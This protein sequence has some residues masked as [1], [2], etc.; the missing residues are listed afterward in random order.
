MAG[1]LIL[2][3]GFSSCTHQ[4]GDSTDIR[5]Q[6]AL[7]AAASDL[8]QAGFN[9]Q[10]LGLLEEACR[11]APSM[12]EAATIAEGYA[13]IDREVE[14]A[15]CLERI[16]PEARPDGL[17]MRILDYYLAGWDWNRA[18]AHID[19]MDGPVG[20]GSIQPLS[21]S[22][23]IVEPFSDPLHLSWQAS[24][25]LARPSSGTLHL[26][27]KEQQAF[28]ERQGYRAGAFG[29]YTPLGWNG[30]DFKLSTDLELIGFGKGARLCWG[31]SA[32]PDRMR[33]DG[34]AKGQ[35][36]RMDYQEGEIALC[37]KA[38]DS[39]VCMRTAQRFYWPIGL[40][41]K[42]SL[43]YLTDPEHESPGTG[44]AGGKVRLTVSD[45][46]RGRPLVRLEC[47]V[48]IPFTSGSMKAG[49]FPLPR[50]EEGSKEGSTACE[51]LLERFVFDN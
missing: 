38:P 41:M 16:F 19:T 10:A 8:E 51:L 45:Q 34:G 44:Y 5:L 14:A 1:A 7:R 27:F 13:K 26:S 11:M 39:P 30:N 15:A 22:K 47:A 37:V 4:G 20:F 24:A 31:L 42:C 23:S 2:A 9:C 21:R 33:T 18:R 46:A 28:T 36:L 17:N 32:H 25:C 49:F 35:F 48:E 50:H 6:A 3:I 12:M 40:W 29:F 43:E